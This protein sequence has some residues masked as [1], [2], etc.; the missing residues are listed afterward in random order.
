MKRIGILLLVFSSMSF[1]LFAQQRTIMGTIVDS[2]TMLPLVGVSI[3]GDST[4]NGCTTDIDGK[5]SMKTTNEVKC[6]VLSYIGYEKKKIE[7]IDKSNIGIITL[8]PKALKLNDITITAQLAVPRR[9][10]VASSTVYANK[11]DEHLGNNEFIEILKTTPGVHINRAGGGWGDSEIFMRGFDNSNVAVMINGVPANDMENGSLYWS[12]WASLSDVASLIQ[13]QRGIGANKLSSPAV[14][15]TINI[16]TKGIETVKGGHAYYMTG[17]DG[18][19]KYAFSLSTGLMKNG[20]A[21]T[22]QGSR[23]SGGGYA[24]GTDFHVYSYFANISKRFNDKHQ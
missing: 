6:L 18:Y 20:W 12:N 21:L 8:D 4:N 14:G 16:V 11:I 19:N 10:P 7:V 22:L 9:T 23:A 17:N 1:T 3:M 5:F 24:T 15:G 13:T 2:E